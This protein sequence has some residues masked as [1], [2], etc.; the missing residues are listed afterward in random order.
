MG[1]HKQNPIFATHL[2]RWQLPYVLWYV[3]RLGKREIHFNLLFFQFILF[4]FLCIF[5]RVQIFW[6]DNV[7][8]LPSDPPQTKRRCGLRKLDRL[9]ELIERGDYTWQWAKI[10]SK[11]ISDYPNLIQVDYYQTLMQTISDLQPKIKYSIQGKVFNDLV[12]IMMIEEIGLKAKST[13]ISDQWYKI[14]QMALKNCA[15]SNETAEQNVQLLQIMIENGYIVSYAFIE[16]IM[17]EIATNTI[18]KSTSSVR[19]M[20]AIFQNVNMDLLTS[21]DDIKASVINWLSP[22]IA[23]SELKR[24]IGNEEDI[25]IALVAELYVLCVLSKTDESLKLSFEQSESMKM[26]ENNFDAI[27]ENLKRQFSYQLFDKLM[28][29][30][31]S[32][33]VDHLTA[34]KIISVLPEAKS[35]DVVLNENLYSDLE[36]SLNP[37]DNLQPSANTIDDFTII[38]SSLSTYINILNQLLAYNAFDKTRYEKS[39]LYKRIAIKIVQ[40]NTLMDRLMG[41]DEKDKF[42]VVEKLNSIWKFGL[43]PLVEQLVFEQDCNSR[44]I[45]WLAQ[46][47]QPQ[48]RSCTQPLNRIT[49][50]DLPFARKMQFKCLVLLTKFSTLDDGN[51]TKAFRVLDDLDIDTKCNENLFIMFELVR[52]NITLRSHS[53]FGSN[54]IHSGSGYDFSRLS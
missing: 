35:V 52:V 1:D 31:C 48:L 9:S 28:A 24:I 43:H 12:R 15:T 11:L 30:D 19:L 17:K 53:N 25:D 4:I 47:M 13:D 45:E 37:D 41:C 10:L 7:W 42:D 50:A 40:L 16:T 32:R 26:D 6:D 27:I 29:V 3:N 38:A 34:S 33:K 18:K 8:V 39:F 54:P 23:A 22:K 44:M 2:F 21:G 51:G 5:I 46:Q 49:F 20:I 36:R 14:M